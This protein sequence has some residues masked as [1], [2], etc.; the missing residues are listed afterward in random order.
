MVLIL[1]PTT[2]S[3]RALLRK[4]SRKWRLLCVLPEAKVELRDSCIQWSCHTRDKGDWDMLHH[5]SDSFS[6]ATQP[7][8]TGSL[9]SFPDS[10]R[11]PK[12]LSWDK[13]STICCSPSK[14][15][16]RL[17]KSVIASTG[18]ISISDR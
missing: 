8:T 18:S 13:Y 14:S 12:L 3:A 15:M 5:Q 9:F 2:A 11:L 16:A 10:A 17:S 6:V 7:A 1:C 4:I